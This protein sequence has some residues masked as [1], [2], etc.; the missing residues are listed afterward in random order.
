MDRSRTI[1]TLAA[2]LAALTVGTFVL[3]ALET[4]PAQPGSL[5]PLTA[6]LPRDGA[7]LSEIASTAVA[8]PRDR[9]RNIVIHDS[10]CSMDMNPTADCH[11][12]IYGPAS[13]ALDG[14]VRATPR[15]H[16]QA[17]GNHVSVPGH[18]YD[19]VS[20]GICL[21]G[22]LVAATPSPRQIEALAN[23]TQALQRRLS[24]APERIYLHSDL[25]GTH[26]PGRRFPLEAFR[27]GLL[28]DEP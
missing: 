15:W 23:L 8:V 16:Q 9:W 24:I 2:L 21:E 14:T 26:C 22:D 19:A 28:P 6:L 4:R 25:S 7:I 27:S 13:G 20:I 10:V 5:P 1:K 12:V 18:D 11:F 3:L 17:R